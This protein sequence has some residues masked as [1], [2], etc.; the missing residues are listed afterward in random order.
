M[1]NVMQ[2]V[3]YLILTDNCNLNC[4]F[5]IKKE[6][7]RDKYI[8]EKIALD[9]LK[10]ICKKIESP[11]IHLWGGE[12]LLNFEVLKKI[13]ETYPQLHFY[14][15]SNGILLDEYKYKWFLE[16]REYVDLIISVGGYRDV[17]EIPKLALKFVKDAKTSINYIV[18]DVK[19][20]HENYDYLTYYTKRILL[21]LPQ[22]IDISDEDI[23]EFEKAYLN[24]ILKYKVDIRSTTYDPIRNNTWYKYFDDW[25]VIR[26]AANF[27][28][29]GIE[30]LTI[31]T[32]GNIWQCDGFYRNC[33]NCLGD[34]YKGI[35]NTKLDYL[36]KFLKYPTLLKEFCEGCNI[37][38]TCP[39]SKCLAQNYKDTGNILKPSETW[40]KI[41]KMWIRITERYIKEIK[42]GCK[43]N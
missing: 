22:G 30:K 5:C 37:Y 17:N 38:D 27:C 2:N 13:V 9:S 31:D 32:E 33:Q 10:W 39:R 11:A 23:S 7:I 29:T 12:P 18:S 41:N 24:I 35:D 15:N 19:K 43:V 8:S 42:N 4:N 28:D 6:I 34:I 21:D 3:Y 25:K 16:R 14:I 20:L 40:C 26:D 1:Q 36:N